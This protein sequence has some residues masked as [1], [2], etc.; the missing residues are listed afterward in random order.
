MTTG[1][2]RGAWRALERAFWPLVLT[3]V[4]FVVLDV[5][6]HLTRRSLRSATSLHAAALFGA[7]ALA[8][9][10]VSCALRA[11]HLELNVA[12]ARGEPTTTGVLVRRLRRAH[13]VAATQIL[14]A[15]FA[16][17]CAV[18]A[19][20]PG[21]ALLLLGDR[22]GA[23]QLVIPLLGLAGFVVGWSIATAAE[24]IAIG[25]HV[26]PVNALREAIRRSRG[27]RGMLVA[28]FLATSVIEIAGV[29]VGLLLF[30][31]GLVFTVP[32]TRAFSTAAYA[33]AYLQLRVR[34]RAL[35]M[36]GP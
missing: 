12:V 9:F 6:F 26:G 35:P 11:G 22:R 29:L 15:V 34:S 17:V 8:F 5:L 10:G 20:L 25:E 2:L 1:A 28:L 33:H 23:P 16:I 13:V 19:A 30:G 36:R 24:W 3:S 4:P 21:T 14:R 31:G 7:L 27:C 18:A 32:A